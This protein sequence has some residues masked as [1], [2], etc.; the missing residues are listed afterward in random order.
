V[1][2]R[3]GASHDRS[4][5]IE[6]IDRTKILQNLLKLHN[7]L[8]QPFSTHLEKRHKISL[9]EFRVLMQIGHLEETASHEVAERLGV[10]TMAV[11]RAVGSLHRRGRISVDVD[12]SSRRRKVLRLTAEGQRLYA[13]MLPAAAQVSSYLFEA[14]RPDEVLAFDHYVQT[15]TRQLEARDEQGR[16]IFLER[17]RPVTPE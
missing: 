7:R 12:P 6:G 11:S 15:L 16:S 3:Q 14:L 2:T 13:E 8:L 17:T 9:N 10:N 1:N 5:L 4:S